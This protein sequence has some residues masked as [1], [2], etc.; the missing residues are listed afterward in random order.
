M[1]LESDRFPYVPVTFTVGE[2]TYTLDALV[3][4]GFEGDLAVPSD[5]VTFEDAPVG[6]TDWYMADGSQSRASLYAGVVRIGSMAPLPAG[7]IV[8]GVEIIL[9]R[10]V[11]DR[12]RVILNRG[13][14]IV[15]EA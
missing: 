5:F 14:R 3:D 12:Y 8:F 4:T 2:Q 13:E 9:G 7:I 11:I 15:I 10:G 6:S 1:T